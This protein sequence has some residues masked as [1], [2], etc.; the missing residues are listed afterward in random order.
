MAFACSDSSRKNSE[1]SGVHFA[2]ANNGTPVAIHF[3]NDEYHLFFRNENDSVQV[4]G[5]LKSTNLLFWEETAPVAEFSSDKNFKAASIVRD[6]NNS[7][8][9]GDENGPLLSFFLKDNIVS[10]SISNDFGKSWK[11]SDENIDLGIDLFF[12]NDLKVLWNEDAQKW[13][14]LMLKDYQVEFYSSDNLIDWEYQSVFEAEDAV[15]K[16][17][18]KAVEFS[19]LELNETLEIKWCLCITTDTGAPNGGFG[20]QYFVGDFN[21]FQFNTDDDV[22]WLDNG[23]DFSAAVI[24]SDYLLLNKQPVCIGK[25][26]NEETEANELFSFPRTLSLIKKYNEFFICSKPIPELKQLENKTKRIAEN[27]FSGELKIEK[28]QNLPLEINL[29][30]DLNNRKYLDFAEVFGVILENEN[31]EKLIIGYH[32]LRRYFFISFQNENDAENAKVDYA[33]GIIDNS[34]VDIKLIIDESSVELFAMEGLVSMTK[35]YNSQS[36]LNRIKLFTENGKMNL[37]EGSITQ[38]SGISN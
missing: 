15:K 5:Q 24:L 21:E 14:M 16:G 12:V 26:N 31:H 30:F 29:T 33:P 28:K 25:I 34:E 20:T 1:K 4:L 36:V 19:P 7:S 6:W 13:I 27:E 38:L 32:N 8:G 37:K 9:L 22:K 3:F 10:Y 2:N 18:W 17:V 35:K 11:M 23:T